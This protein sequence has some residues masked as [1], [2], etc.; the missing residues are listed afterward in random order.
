MR[1]RRFTRRTTGFSRKLANHRAAVAL[2][3]AVHNF[4]EMHLS[5]PWQE[6]AWPRARGLRC[7]FKARGGGDAVPSSTTSNAGDARNPRAPEGLR[8][9]AAFCGVAAPRRCSSIACVAAPCI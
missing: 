2:F 8:R 7:G 6:S 9:R 4:V 1:C 3:V 5:S